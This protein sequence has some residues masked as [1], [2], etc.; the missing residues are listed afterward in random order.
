MSQTEQEKKT[1][2]QNEKVHVVV[3]KKPEC[4]IEYEVD[5]FSPI[6]FEAEKKA[7]KTIGKEVVVPGF[8]K[9]KA[10]PEIVKK[11]YPHDFDKR[12]QEEIANA[13]FK[14]SAMLAQVPLIRND[15]TITFKMESHSSEKAK[16]TL[17]FETVPVIPSI[18]PAKCVLT[19]I[20]RPE[21][22]KEKVDETIRQ[23]QMFFAKW[24]SIE[25]RPIQENDFVLLDVDVIEQDPPETLFS[26]TRFEVSDKSMA[27]WMKPLVLGKNVGDSVE[28][29]STPDESLSEEEKS[30]YTPKKVKITIKAIEEATLPALDDEFAKQVGSDSVDAFTVKIEEILNKKADE[31]V[32]EKQREQVTEFLL[33]HP[34]EIPASVIQKETQFRIEQMMKDSHFQEMWKTSSQKER[35]ELVET[36]KKQAEKAVRMY[37]LCRKISADQNLS[38]TPKDAPSSAPDPIEALLYPSATPHDPHQP[39]VKQAEAYSQILLEKT[40]DW[41]ISHARTEAAPKK[42]AAPKK[43]EAKKA[44]P[45]KEAPKKKAAP[46]KTTSAKKAAAKKTAAKKAAPKKKTTSKKSE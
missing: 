25:N 23:A 21:T 33:S 40:E 41:V 29:V 19:E 8:R 12:W 31:H 32:R 42:K 37:Y 35:E 3:H 1:E 38:I 26:N 28:G 13:A 9:G 16:L 17:S 36:T 43:T 7:A 22:T 20:K 30:E 6:C 2:Y 34:F 46:K 45:K 44:E 11:R 14:E 18:D 15:A 5:V 4:M 10:P 27:Q 24:T 39:D